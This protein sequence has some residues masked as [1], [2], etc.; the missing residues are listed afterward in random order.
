MQKVGNHA[1][2]KAA[3]YQL[4]KDM[5]QLTETPVYDLK[6]YRCPNAQVLLNRI[7][8]SAVVN[9]VSEFDIVSIEPSLARS[10]EARISLQHFP[11]QIEKT[12]TRDI[13]EADITSWAGDFDAEDYGDI[14]TINT[15]HLKLEI[16]NSTTIANA[17]E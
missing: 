1:L 13:C 10:M 17:A 12:T 11:L 5:N 6:A 16:S 4:M 8:E 3:R 14:T 2:R 7:L 15:F 9:G